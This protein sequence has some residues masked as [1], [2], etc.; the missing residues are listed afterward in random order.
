MMF[1]HYLCVLYII[2]HQKNNEFEFEF[3]YVP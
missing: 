1:E 3:I 2:K